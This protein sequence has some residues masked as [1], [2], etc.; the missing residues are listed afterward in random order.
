MCPWEQ[1]VETQLPLLT[2]PDRTDK[3]RRCRLS[4]LS[5]S[6]DCHSY[7]SSRRSYSQ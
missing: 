5:Y 4:S 6:T 3:K 1:L 7:T 2:A